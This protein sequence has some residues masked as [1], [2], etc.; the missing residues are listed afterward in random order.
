M[1]N[2][3]KVDAIKLLKQYRIA[4]EGLYTNNE[5]PPNSISITCKTTLLNQP[6]IYS[7]N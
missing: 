5:K 1:E 6:K 2:G 7:I 3:S 4:K